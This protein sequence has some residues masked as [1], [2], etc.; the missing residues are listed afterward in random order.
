MAEGYEAKVGALEL[1]F[2]TRSVG[3]RHRDPPDPS[4]EQ[5]ELAYNLGTVGGAARYRKG[6]RR[7]HRL[8]VPFRGRGAPPGRAAR[9]YRTSRWVKLGRTVRFGPD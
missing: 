7:S 1:A 5:T 6:I 3:E 4:T 2:K 9:L 8:G